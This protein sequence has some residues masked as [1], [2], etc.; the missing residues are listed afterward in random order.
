MV[1]SEQSAFNRLFQKLPVTDDYNRLT[2]EHILNQYNPDHTARHN[3]FPQELMRSVRRSLLTPV[4]DKHSTRTDRW[5]VSH[6]LGEMHLWNQTKDKSIRR[7]ER[8]FVRQLF[9]YG[10]VKRHVCRREWLLAVRTP[11]RVYSL[12]CHAT[13]AYR[14]HVANVELSSSHVPL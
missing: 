10:W 11:R 12:T 5:K 8:G 13:I 7:G 1:S 3:V 2:L 14:L 4:S 9:Y 6:V